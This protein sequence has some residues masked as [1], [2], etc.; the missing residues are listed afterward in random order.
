MDKMIYRV[1]EN[2]KKENGD[3]K[4]Q[5][6]QLEKDYN[7]LFNDWTRDQRVLN[8]PDNCYKCICG[9]ATNCNCYHL[10]KV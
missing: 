7:I 3:L 5:L 9:V 8:D 1:L 2:L 10:K 4:D 6:K